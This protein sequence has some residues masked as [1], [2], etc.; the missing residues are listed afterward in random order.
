MLS[1][2]PFL[3]PFL[4]NGRSNAG[5][6]RFD[7]RGQ[8]RVSDF[9]GQIAKRRGGR[10]PALGRTKRQNGCLKCGVFGDPRVLKKRGRH[11]SSRRL[12]DAPSLPDG[13]LLRLCFAASAAQRLGFAREASA[14][15]PSGDT[16]LREVVKNAPSLPDGRLLCLCAAGC[17]SRSENALCRTNKTAGKQG[18][19]AANPSLIIH[20]FLFF[21]T[22]NHN[23]IF[24]VS[25]AVSPEAPPTALPPAASEALK[26]RPQNAGSEKSSA[27]ALKSSSCFPVLE[28]GSEP[29]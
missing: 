3:P 14:D 23:K 21:S 28:F 6:S 25:S 18:T 5:R 8:R 20:N 13:R 11:F 15:L 22:F 29:P 2:L 19:Y 24:S 16:S 7:C 9:Q 4:P 1:F 12:K 26:S 10:R 17:G 27:A